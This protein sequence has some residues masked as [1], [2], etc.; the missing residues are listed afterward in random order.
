MPWGGD[1]FMSDSLPAVEVLVVPVQI[2]E[3]VAF[4]HG[5]AGLK[6]AGWSIL[7]LSQMSPSVI[8]FVSGAV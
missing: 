7:N 1:V 2:E 4:F 6:S 3:L 8:A 5:A